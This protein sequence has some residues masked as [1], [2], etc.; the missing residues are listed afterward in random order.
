MIAGQRGKMD[1]IV[2]NDKSS[3]NKVLRAVDRVELAGLKCIY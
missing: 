2:I 1:T 3:L